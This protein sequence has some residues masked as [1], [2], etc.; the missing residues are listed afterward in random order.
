[1]IRK[2]RSGGFVNMKVRIAAVFRSSFLQTFLFRRM[3]IRLLF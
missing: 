2:L 1:M 3:S